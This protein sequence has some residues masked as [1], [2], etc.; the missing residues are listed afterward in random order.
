MPSETLNIETRIR[1]LNTVLTEKHDWQTVDEALRAANGDMSAALARLKGKLPEA[2]LQ[3]VPLAH[4]L[5]VWSNDHVSVV[6]AL[7]GQADITNLRDVALRFHV[8]KLTELVDLKAVPA[9]TVGATDDEK[10]QNFA[11]ALHNKL[12]TAE[13]TAVLHRMVQDAEVPITDTNH[14]TGVASFLTNQPEFNI[15]ATSV[16]TALKHPDAFEGIADKQHASVVEQVKTLQRVQAISPIPEAI[17]VLFKA[18]LTSAF[19]VAELPESTFIN[20]TEGPWRESRQAGR[21]G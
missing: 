12:F 16:C 2:A 6:K 21:R 20:A 15:C 7:S 9:N 19:R 8:A 13:P 10:K 14:H 11:I 17:P 5:A 4:S 3:K 18:N 1:T